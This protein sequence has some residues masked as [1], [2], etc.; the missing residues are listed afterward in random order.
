MTGHR[1]YSCLITFDDDRLALEAL[2]ETEVPFIGLMGPRDRFQR[3][4]EGLEDDGVTL[5]AA[6]RDRIATPVGLDLG[7]ER[8]SKSR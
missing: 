1:S 7:A 5:S 8:P 6:D 2:L 3:I 4:R